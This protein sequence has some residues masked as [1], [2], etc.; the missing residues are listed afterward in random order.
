MSMFDEAINACKRAKELDP[1][2]VEV[3]CNLGTAY[4]KKGMFEEANKEFEIACKLNPEL[5]IQT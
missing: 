4:N 2:S 1:N 3:Y 5:K